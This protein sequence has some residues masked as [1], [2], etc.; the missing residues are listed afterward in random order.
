MNYIEVVLFVIVVLGALSLLMPGKRGGIPHVQA[1]PLMTDAEISFWKM[2][3][4]AAA[5]LL[6]APQ[7]AMGAL[8]RTGGGL[9]NRERR[10]TRN[11][12]DRKIIDFV[13]IDDSGKVK[14]IV[15]LDD[16]T[17]DKAR[18]AFRDAMIA[19]AGYK[20]VRLRRADCRNLEALRQC[21]GDR[22]DSVSGSAIAPEAAMAITGN[23]AA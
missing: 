12:F 2:L 14:L 4:A 13:L 3:R 1:K 11:R 9:D 21:I 23:T 15:E 19:K 16:K 18:D 10:S 5:P 17:H 7:V 22:L 20:T 6:V 8:L